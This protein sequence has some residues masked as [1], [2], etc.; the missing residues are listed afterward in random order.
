MLEESNNMGDQKVHTDDNT[1]EELNKIE[2]ITPCVQFDGA[3]QPSVNR[4]TNERKGDINIIRSIAKAVQ[5]VARAT[6]PMI[7]A[8]A[9]K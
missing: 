7:L 6:P 2:S 5:R 9:V 8:L 4:G 1:T 3:Q